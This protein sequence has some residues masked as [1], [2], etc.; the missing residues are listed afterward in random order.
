VGFVSGGVGL[1]ARS[2]KKVR[3]LSE[4]SENLLTNSKARQATIAGILMVV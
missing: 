3:R 4:N 2:A 1:A